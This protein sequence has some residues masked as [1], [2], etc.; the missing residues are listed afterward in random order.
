[1]ERE[2]IQRIREAARTGKLGKE[3]TPAQVNV[4]LRM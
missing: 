4:V 1:M 2:T 3:F